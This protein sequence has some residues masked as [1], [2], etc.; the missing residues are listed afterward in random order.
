MK[1]KDFVKETGGSTRD[2]AQIDPRELKVRPDFNIRDLTTPGAREKLDVLKAQIKAEGVLEPLEIQF[3][4]ETPW[5]NEGHRRHMV[6]ME[7][8]AE[9]EEF[10][11]IPCVQERSNIKPATRTLHM[12]M[13]SKEDYEPLEYAKGIDRMVN[14]YGWD[15]AEL[16]RSLGFKSKGSIEDYLAMIGMDDRVKTQVDQGIVSATAALKVT[17][18][19]R[20]A[21]TDPTFAAQLIQDAA[22]EQKRLGKKGKATP[23]ALKAASERAKP[24]PPAETKPSAP[25]PT[26][27]LPSGLPATPET[28]GAAVSGAQ[29]LDQ[30]KETI[31]GLTAG[32]DGSSG[33]P[34]VVEDEA[35]ATQT[36]PVFVGIDMASG[37]DR[38]A[39]TFSFMSPRALSPEEILLIGFISADKHA[40]AMQYAKLCRE[41]EE[42]AAQGEATAAHEQL[43]VAADVAGQLRFPD[44]WDNAKAS[45]ELAQVA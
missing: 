44:D 36:K 34:V 28:E 7:L 31:A 37:P 45:T 23:K 29:S 30:L 13:R 22:D 8:I 10:K 5:I 40:L 9:G 18:E 27:P 17:K 11:T 43:C 26:A 6:V 35:A 12:L 24:K 14:V 21:K 42:A 38:T 16:A 19:T 20:D 3:D 4:G 15:K 1:L 25:A 33:S 39:Q 32:A 41:R 2:Y